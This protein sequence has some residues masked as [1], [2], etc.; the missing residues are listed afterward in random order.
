MLKILLAGEI[1]SE[2]QYLLDHVPNA[3]EVGFAKSVNILTSSKIINAGRIL[4]ANNDVTMWGVIGDDLD[5]KQAVSDLKKY[6]IKPELVYTTKE[7]P[8]AQVL[9][10]TDNQGDSSIIL[11]LAAI[12]YFNQSSLK[13]LSDF[14]YLYLAT[15]MPLHQLYQLIERANNENVKIFLDFPNQQKEFDKEKLKAVN[16]V[17]PNRQEAELLLDTKITSIKEAL[18]AVKKLKSYTNGLAIIT[19]DNEGCVIS[20]NEVELPK[21]YTT[22]KVDVVDTTGSGDIFRGVFLNEY[23]KT[24]NIDFSIKKALELATESVKYKGVNNSIEV[25]KNFLN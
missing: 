2:K 17:V 6:G 11:H 13:N 4:A 21:H 3:K 14:N 7:A 12:N 1:C 15:S 18:E 24:N 5:G 20:S 8:T 25:V 10:L 23:I 22:N 19:L 9:V 16:F